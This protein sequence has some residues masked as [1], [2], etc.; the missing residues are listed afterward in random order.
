MHVRVFF[1]SHLYIYFVG[2]L[3]VNIIVVHFNYAY[4]W[5]EIQQ[6]LITSE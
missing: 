6:S 1:V 3:E 5:E 4:H 2:I